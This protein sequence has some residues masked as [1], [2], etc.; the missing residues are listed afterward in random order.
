MLRLVSLL[1]LVALAFPSAA[2]AQLHARTYA[3][4]FSLPLAFIQDPTDRTVQFVVQQNGRIRVVRSGAVQAADFLDL[5]SVVSSGGEQGLLGLAF[6][7]DTSS[8]RFFVN[9]TD[10]S[11]NTVVARFKRSGNPLVADASSRFDFRWGGAGGPAYIDQPYANHNG[12]NIAFGPDGFLYIG[13][14][15][16]GSGDDPG[17]RSQTPSEL[18]GK[19]LR[20]DVNV[21]DSDQIGYR[22]PSTNPFVSS[23]PAGTRPEIWAYGLRNPWRWSFDDPARGGTGA[24]IIGDVGQNEW[25]EVDYEP[26]ARGGRNYGWRY[27]EGAHNHVTAA[28]P[29]YLPLTDPIHEFDHNTGQSITGG[30]V[31][32]GT[33]LGPAFRGRY[34]FADFVA[35]RVWS[36]GLAINSSTGEATKTGIVEHTAELGGTSTLGNISSFGVD[37]DGELYIVSYSRGVILKVI[38]PAGQRNDFDGD[39]LTDFTVFRP[40]NGNWFSLNSSAGNTTSSVRQWGL[41]GDVPVAGDYDG[42]GVTDLAV[43]RPGSG[44]WFVVP[45]TT[46]VGTQR[47]WGFGADTPSHADIP[48]PADYDG[49]GKTDLAVYRP[50]WGVWFI[51][52]SSTG[53][54]VKVGLGTNT[55]IPVPGDYDGD[56]AADVAVYRPSS[57]MWIIRRSTTSGATTLELQ[58]GLAGDVPVPA[59]YDGDGLTDAA[60][61]R[62]STGVWY[63]RQSS[64]GFVSSVSYQW[65]LAGDLTAPG[66]YDGD[67]RIDLA[68]Y[69]PSNGT[70]FI[71]TST[72]GYASYFLV[73][74][75][76]GG[77]TPVPNAPIRAVIDLASARPSGSALASLLRGSDF[78]GDARSDITIFRP[79][80]GSWYTKQSSSEYSGVAAYQWGLNGD[81]PVAADYDGDGTTDFAVWRP[82]TGVWYLLQSSTGFGT[83]L[84]VQW[85]LNGDVPVPGDYDGDGRADLAVWRPANGIWYILQSST[86]FTAALTYQWGL[87]SDTTVPGDYDGDGVSDLAVFRP[88][89]A[90]WYVRTSL[91]AFTDTLVVQWGLTGDTAAPGDYDGDGKADFAVWRPSNGTWFARLTSLNSFDGSSFLSRQFGLAG[92]IPVPGDYDGDRKTDFAV[93]RPSTSTWYL[94][95]SSSNFSSASVYQWG[96]PGDIPILHRP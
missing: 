67:G 39:G 46:G 1:L 93:F 28:P 9:F 87:S 84:A 90:T 14:G 72:T 43:Y 22:V 82:S 19:M 17:N 80:N 32:R 30:Y 59:D 62:P 61:Y 55:D 13:M 38:A 75:G 81:V 60:V 37:A 26:A 5:R 83:S 44:T 36:M 45:S 18:L 76:L 35:G 63:V 11:G 15:D 92:D 94:L 24:L 56:A 41:D 23:G 78:D 21:A 71:R 88:S 47:Q 96:L 57:G 86:S 73:S 66:D 79:S 27:R 65:G 29:A 85:G 89:T 68:V 25:E 3:S 70:W 6:A 40:S 16:G 95:S 49:D 20:V 69:R 52:K 50:S 58:W 64:T 91:T 48:S 77:D 51:V 12:G 34:F 8:G 74:W 10:T 53:A 54:T 33:S 7:P 4:G 31:Y 2:R 42:D